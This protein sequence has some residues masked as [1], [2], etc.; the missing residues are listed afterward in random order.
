MPTPYKEN[1]V[2]R[3]LA[4]GVLCRALKLGLQHPVPE[5]GP[6]V[7]SDEGREALRRAAL[8]LD[9]G[10][11]GPILAAIVALSRLPRT[12]PSHLS[13]SHHRLFGP[14]LR[15]RVCPY[16]TEYGGSALFQQAHELADISGFY[17]A[18]GLEPAHDLGERMD[19]VSCEFEFLE[20]LSLKEAYAV[21]QRD[22]EMFEVT[23]GA[24][25]SFLRDHIGRFGWAFGF[26]LQ[27]EDRDGFHGALGTVCV[28]FLDSE[29][30]RFGVPV[31]PKLLQLRSGE[32]D[33]VP[34][35]CGSTG[36]LQI[37]SSEGP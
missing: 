13:E 5:L 36:L 26:S 35:A 30:R 24:M 11:D 31:G 21:E 22:D 4:R 23:R 28:A 6:A 15:G 29:C 18:F 34:M 33:K 12:S 3:S 7:L 14:T 2:Q 8:V 9:G 25:R 32:D 37:G 17:L 19:H 1:D 27:K 16:E 10:E 20:F